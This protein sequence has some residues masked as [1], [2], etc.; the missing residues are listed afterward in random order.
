M[1]ISPGCLCRVD[2]AVPSVNG[3]TKVD[4][5]PATYYENWQQGIAVVT[6]DQDDKF[7]VDLVQIEDG[8]AWFRGRKFIA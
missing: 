7:H 3:S 6:V 5:T 4:G 1:A 8:V 2:G